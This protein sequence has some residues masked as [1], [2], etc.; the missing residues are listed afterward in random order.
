MANT[1]G[2]VIAAT[3][4]GMAALALFWRVG[5]WQVSRAASL[6]FDEGLR[7]GSRA[8]NLVG[9]TETYQVDL[10]WGDRLTF[11]AFGDEGCDPCRDLVAAAR[12]HPATKHMRLVY[13]TGELNPDIDPTGSWEIYQYDDEDS[14]R[15]L[16]RVPPVS[17][18]FYVIDPRG[19]IMDKGV[20]NAQDHLDRLFSLLPPAV[21][22]AIIFQ[23][24]PTNGE[25]GSNAH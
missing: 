20:A 16:W 12:N 6:T 15:E 19:Q 17:P 8:P 13:V 2:L 22:P 10:N 25:R 11:L 14:T 23:T 5:S 18:Y 4:L 21:S 3:L 24:V 1:V 9:S 7:L